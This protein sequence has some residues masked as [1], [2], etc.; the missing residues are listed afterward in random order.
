M[1]LR[2]LAFAKARE[3]TGGGLSLSVSDSRSECMEEP[4]LVPALEPKQRSDAE[5][6]SRPPAPL[7]QERRAT[8]A[9]SNL[10]RRTTSQRM[11]PHGLVT[12]SQPFAIKHGDSVRH[13]RPPG[14]DRVSGLDLAAFTKRPLPCLQIRPDLWPHRRVARVLEGL[15]EFFEQLTGRQGARKSLLEGNESHDLRMRHL[16]IKNLARQEAREAHA[17]LLGHVAP[18]LHRRHARVGI[19]ASGPGVCPQRPAPPVTP[20]I[21]PFPLDARTKS[22]YLT[23]P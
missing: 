23:P 17:G 2:P 4:G 12:K 21:A 22:P 10:N 20:P 6:A 18:R 19:R 9:L 8:G 15:H 13:G 14:P 1:N 11:L 16:K 3:D 5:K 7:P